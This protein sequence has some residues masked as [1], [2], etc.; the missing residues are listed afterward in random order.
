MNNKRVLILLLGLMMAAGRQVEAQGRSEIALSLGGGSLQANTGGGATVVFSC[1]YRFH[2]TQHFSVEGALD[3]FNYN[4]PEYAP[5]DSS[6]FRDEYL[7]AEA[8]IVYHF[9]P[10]RDTGRLLP[11]VA[12]G[13]GKTTTDFTEIAAHPYYR[14]GAGVNYHLNDML[15]F[16]FEVRDE[17]I[18][19]L[20]I[21][22][23]PNANLPSVRGGIVI[24]F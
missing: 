3:M 18:K 12:A 4:I 2:I 5:N 7:G 9:L 22:G 16:Q 17:I 20:W 15:G 6:I 10:N 14:L 8:A 24:R 23:K 13:I 19:E 21:Q 11:F 1:S